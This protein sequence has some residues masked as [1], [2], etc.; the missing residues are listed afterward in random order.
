M[1]VEDT[2]GLDADHIPLAFPPGRRP[3][4]GPLNGV[5][6]AG[7]YWKAHLA[8]D[9][10]VRSSPVGDSNGAVSQ[11]PVIAASSGVLAAA[12]PHFVQGR[13]YD[14]FHDA[15]HQSV[16][17]W[18]PVLAPATRAATP[19]L[20]LAAGLLVGLYPS[21]RASRIQPVEALRH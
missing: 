10:S 12:R 21:W 11:T 14:P 1:T 13:G 19:A 18:T 3:E 17:E 20:G 5:D 7:V 16:A 6:A 2:D 9:E 8:S 15:H 4:D